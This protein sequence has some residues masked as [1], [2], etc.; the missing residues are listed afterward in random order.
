MSKID[1]LLRWREIDRLIKTKSTGNT[2]E[3]AIRLGISKS[4]RHE[5]LKNLR[6]LDAPIA[7]SRIRQTYYYKYPTSFS[8]SFTPIL[9]TE[10]AN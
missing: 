5:D 7:Y 9:V 1:Y 10:Q 2:S 4:Q 3:F 8:L 6:D